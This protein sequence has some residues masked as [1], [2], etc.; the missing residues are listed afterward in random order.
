VWFLR[1]PP[2]GT[3][4]VFYTDDLDALQAKLIAAGYSPGPVTLQP[5]GDRDFRLTDPDGYYVRLSE[6]HAI[7][8]AGGCDS[9]QR[10]AARRASST[11][12]VGN[13]S[14]GGDAGSNQPKSTASSPATGTASG[15]TRVAANQMP[16]VGFSRSWKFDAT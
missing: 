2:L 13:A 8:D 11:A 6:G 15:S 10:P 1:H 3:E 14:G 7:P 12:S 9:L 4:I 5:W 16:L